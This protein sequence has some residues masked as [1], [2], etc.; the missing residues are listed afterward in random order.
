MNCP[1][2]ASELVY[3]EREVVPVLQ[4]SMYMQNR[5]IHSRI[6]E[7]RNQEGKAGT[8]TENYTLL[9]ANMYRFWT[10]I[11]EHEE[12]RKKQERKPRGPN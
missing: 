12:N 2:A 7:K 11:V 6:R 4:T 5:Y 1:A 9:Q 10:Y 3:R 8:S